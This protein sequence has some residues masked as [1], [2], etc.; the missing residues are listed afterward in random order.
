[1]ELNDIN[2]PKVNPI[3]GNLGTVIDVAYLPIDFD[4]AVDYLHKN[5]KQKSQ[6][7]CARYVMNALEKAGFKF[8]RVGS[9]YMMADVLVKDLGWTEM[10]FKE[11][12][13][14]P[15]VG[16]I[17]VEMNTKSHPHGHIQMYCG[18]AWY[19]DFKQN[20]KVCTIHVT[21]AG[22]KRY[23]RYMPYEGVR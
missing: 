14:S 21:D 20:S 8:T 23:F 13:N 10:S 11:E 12:I 17:V 3:T 19:S 5:A 9:A 15:Q 2:I 7:L 22:Q 6:S 16:D 18:D 1:M 4:K